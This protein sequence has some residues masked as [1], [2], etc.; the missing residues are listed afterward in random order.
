LQL[1]RGNAS[2]S[3]HAAQTVITIANGLIS[4]GTYQV[5]GWIKP[6]T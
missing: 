1:F 4:G 3:G 5:S 6:P 2:F